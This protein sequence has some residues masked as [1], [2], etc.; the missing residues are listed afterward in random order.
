MIPGIPLV[1]GGTEFLVPP[2][3]LGALELLQD[4][5]SGFTGGMDPASIRTV[6]DAALMA[7]KRNYP[8]MTR[9]QILDLLDVANMMDVFSAIMDI[10]G[11]KRKA[12]DQGEVAGAAS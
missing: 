5:L 3:S 10:S 1:L 9:E 2:L 6:V 7:I 12:I 8:E 11:L 4:R